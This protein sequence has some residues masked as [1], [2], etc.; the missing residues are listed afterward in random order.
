MSMCWHSE[1]NL[2]WIMKVTF[3]IL[4]LSFLALQFV[5]YTFGYAT[6]SPVKRIRDG[7]YSC[8]LSPI[9]EKYPDPE[10]RYCEYFFLCHRGH[11]FPRKCPPLHAFHPLKVECVK[12]DQ[13]P[14]DVCP[15]GNGDVIY[16]KHYY[17]IIK[18]FPEMRCG[19]NGYLA[20]RRG[21]IC[22][23]PNEICWRSNC[24]RLTYNCWLRYSWVGITCP[25]SGE[26]L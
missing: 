18:N 14:E 4:S 10:S 17:A 12:R 13:I 23:S 19:F 2:K 21:K 20:D 25:Y 1:I 15:Y 16:K 22:Y 3:L 8:P 6:S 24:S 26:T 9:T 11:A 5:D 7:V